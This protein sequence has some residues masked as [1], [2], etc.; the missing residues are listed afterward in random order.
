MSKKAD[1]ANNADRG[2]IDELTLEIYEAKVRDLTEK[3]NRFKDKCDNLTKENDAL[4]KAQA[5]FSSDKQDIVEF[6]NIKVREHE[7]QIT[8]LEEKVRAQEDEM[9]ER[10]QKAKADMEHAISEGKLELEQAMNQGARYK[11]ELDQLFEFKGR[12]VN[13]GSVFWTGFSHC[14]FSKDE[15]EFQ[16]KRTSLLLETKEK[17]YKD[18]IHTMER[19]VLQDKVKRHQQIWI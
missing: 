18:I 8:M 17:E 19:K 1:E 10:D 14:C 9:R 12:K 6:L 5:K 7:E 2:K 16:L 3:L 11:A 15:L 4:G 13:P